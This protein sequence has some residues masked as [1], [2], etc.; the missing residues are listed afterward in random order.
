MMLY[1]NLLC[2]KQYGTIVCLKHHLFCHYT[3]MIFQ[4]VENMSMSWSVS[5]V[6]QT[7]GFSLMNPAPLSVQQP[8]HDGTELAKVHVHCTHFLVVD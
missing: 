6:G 1:N 2:L 8:Q 5:D 7:P 3:S 4:T